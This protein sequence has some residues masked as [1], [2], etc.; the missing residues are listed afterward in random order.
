MKVFYDISIEMNGDM[1]VYPG[2]PKVEIIEKHQIAQGDLYN[3]SFLSFGSH[4]GTHMDAPKHF[5]DSGMTV[6]Q[7]PLEHF[8]GRAKVLDMGNRDFIDKTCLEPYPINKGD[9]ILFK[10]KNSLLMSQGRFDQNYVY[11]TPEAAAYLVELKIRT[12]GIDFLTVEKYGADSPDTHY[13]FLRNNV[14][15]LEGLNLTDIEE[16]EY[17]LISPPIKISGGNGSPMRAILVKEQQED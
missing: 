11:I 7:L 2:D 15:I 9:I 10:T 16:G 1:L 14:V 13:A 6:D 5:V 4:T 17:D 12:V 8:I 3:L